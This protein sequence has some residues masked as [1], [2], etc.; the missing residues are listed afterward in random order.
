MSKIVE[1][2]EDTIIWESETKSETSEHKTNTSNIIPFP[3]RTQ[4][5]HEVTHQRIIVQPDAKPIKI[6]S[7]GFGNVRG[8]LNNVVRGIAA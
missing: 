6:V 4:V 8:Q 1:K 2:S 7:S 5:V 3:Q